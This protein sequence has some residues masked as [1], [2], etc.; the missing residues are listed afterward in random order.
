MTQIEHVNPV[1]PARVR[2]CLC[3]QTMGEAFKHWSLKK[4]KKYSCKLIQSML[5]ACCNQFQLLLLKLLF[6]CNY[7]H[8]TAFL[9]NQIPYV[10]ICFQCF[11]VWSISA[12]Y[13]MFNKTVF[14]QWF[15]WFLLLQ[16]LSDMIHF[17][18]KFVLKLFNVYICKN[19]KVNWVNESKLSM[20]NTKTCWS[21][22]YWRQINHLLIV[23]QT[24]IRLTY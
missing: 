15:F 4:K 11:L 7:P 6:F 12:I 2:W 22:L 3:W 18:N 23:F 19:V 24:S 21:V 14:T 8:R 1:A 16:F 5:A 17:S 9:W 10:H 20:T 13:S